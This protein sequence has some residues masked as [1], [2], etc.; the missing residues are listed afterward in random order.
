MTDPN[1]TAMLLVIDRSGSM[2][3]IRDD[4]V[5]GL[6]AMIAEQAKRPGLLTLDVVTF[7]DVIEW[8]CSMADATA[9][10]ISLDPRGMTA[11]FDAIGVSVTEFGRALAA[12]P[13]HARPETV[14]VVVVTDGH[15]NSSR[16][17]GAGAVRALVSQQQEKYG[18][19]FVFL[20]ANQDAVL[21]GE[22]LGFAAD[23]SLTYTTDAAAVGAVSA[24][25]SRYV[26]DVRSKSKRGFSAEE[27]RAAD[28]DA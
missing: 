9:T 15:E 25:L 16:E 7:D 2:S 3:T 11:L 6:N 20:G 1:Y 14:Q 23:S 17:Y 19:D 13:E 28:G 8:Q 5:G 22:S 24:N 21:T 27:R 18:W 12:L 10:T 26:S 4:M